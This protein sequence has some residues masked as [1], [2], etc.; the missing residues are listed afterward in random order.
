MNIASWLEATAH[1]RPDAPAVFPG[2]RQI[3]T[4]AEFLDGDRKS[5]V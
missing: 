3:A 1:A 5:V 2:T 4:Y